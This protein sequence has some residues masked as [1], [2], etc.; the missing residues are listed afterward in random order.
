MQER[1]IL[2]ARSV[3]GDERREHGN[4]HEETDE[5]E[6]GDRA[7]VAAKPA[8]GVMPE[9]TRRLEA[10]LPS[11]DLGDRHQDTLIRGLMSA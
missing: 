9:P 3:G 1:E 2:L 6:P 11:L 10:D 5:D 7:G 8:P 4:G